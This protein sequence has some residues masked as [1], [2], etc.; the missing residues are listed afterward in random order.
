MAKR[1]VTLLLS[2][3]LTATT[4]AQAQQTLPEPRVPITNPFPT[5]ADLFA[6]MRGKGTLVSAHRGG[7]G[8][9]FPENAIETAARTLTSGP[10]LIETDIH[11]SRDGVL[12]LMH[13]DTLDRTSSGTGPIR[14]Q[15]WSALQKLALKDDDGKPTAFHIPRL[16]DAIEWTRNRALLLAEVKESD[17]LP[18]V[19][20]E[21][22]QAHAQPHVM[23][24]I[25]S[26]DDAARLQNLDPTIT[27]T[28]E[29]PDLAQLDRYAAAGIDLKHV[30]AWNGIGKRDRA[31]WKTLHNR[32]MT[33]AYGTLWFVDG[34]IANL[35]LKGI[36]AEL[37][38]DGVD[39]LATDRAIEA[40][41]EIALVRPIEAAL[42]Q[43]RAIA[44]AKAK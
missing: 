5:V 28:L 42:R 32:D 3:V 4:P 30:I 16:S 1:L 26:L 37:A 6:C 43:C 44:P 22:R 35:G 9:G 21:I 29:V 24:L 38:R 25:N 34:A 36:Y 10:V 40:N 17:T 14:N 11:R 23:L 15:D 39:L 12:V 13:D 18:Q 20:A 19:V 8:S 7:V 2:T 31:L 41:A 33:L 27:M